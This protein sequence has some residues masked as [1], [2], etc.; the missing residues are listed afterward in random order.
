NIPD[1]P[2][3]NP[4]EEFGIPIIP[5]TNIDES[6]GN[7]EENNIETQ[8]ADIERRRQ[9]SLYIV[10]QKD[11]D[12]GNDVGIRKNED[13]SIEGE[14]WNSNEVLVESYKGSIKEVQNKI[15]A[16][17]DAELAALE[18]QITSQQKQQAQ[19]S[20]VIVKEGVKELFESNPEL[21]N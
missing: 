1:V 11:I 4:F 16:K 10:T 2:E 21:A 14:V 8:K 19:Q 9:E 15:N 7:T 18:A 13:G 6:I 5:D 20:N 3:G 12:E 17:Y